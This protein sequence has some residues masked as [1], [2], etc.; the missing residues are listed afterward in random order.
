MVELLIYIPLYGGIVD[1][2]TSLWWNC[3]YTYPFMV[4]LLKC[5][6]LYGGIVDIHIRPLYGGIVEM[7]TP[8]WWNCWNAYPFMVEL[9]IYI[10]LCDKPILS[11]TIHQPVINLW[12]NWWYT[13]THLPV[14]NLS[15]QTQCITPVINLELLI[16]IPLYGGIGDIHIQTWHYGGIGDIHTPLWWNW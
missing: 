15:C 7:H 4:E 5:I 9:L 16:Y 6:P 13:D 8:L 11:D 14:I 1:I 3:W 10:P 12:W 2:H